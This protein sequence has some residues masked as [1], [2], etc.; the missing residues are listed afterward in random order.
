M[1]KK[2]AR[3]ALLIGNSEYGDSNLAKLHA[4]YH[5]VNRLAQ[6]LRDPNI[7]GFDVEVLVNEPC[8]I[9]RRELSDVLRK[10]NRSDFITLYF[11]GHGVKDDQGRLYLTCTDSELDN[12][13]ATSVGAQFVN[14]MMNESMSK[15][16]LLILDCCH[17]GAVVRGAMSAADQTVSTV[18][19]FGGDRQGRF[20]LTACDAFQYAWDGEDMRE[21]EGKPSSAFSR[22]LIEGLISGDADADRDGVITVNEMADYVTRKTIEDNPRQEPRRFIF[23]ALGDLHFAKNRHGGCG[24]QRKRCFVISPLSRGD[25]RPDEVLKHFIE[26]AC[27]KAGY[28]AVRSDQQLSEKVIPELMGALRFDPMVVAYL[29]RPPWNANVMIEVGFRLA[30]GKPMVM[31]REAEQDDGHPE[32]PL[33]FDLHSHRVIFLPKAHDVAAKTIGAAVKQITELVKARSEARSPWTTAQARAKVRFDLGKETC[34]FFSASAMASQLFNCPD[35]LEN[36]DLNEVVENLGKLMPARQHREFLQDQHALIG[37]IM[38][39]AYLG[40]G[41]YRPP[42]AT[43]PI[44]FHRHDLDDGFVSRAYLPVVTRYSKQGTELWLDVIYLDVT[45]ATRKDRAIP[46]SFVCDLTGANGSLETPHET[47]KALPADEPLSDSSGGTF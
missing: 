41:G 9:V 11:A 13:Q 23:D 30:A 46:G 21:L 16:Q 26:P 22:H 7:G 45:N 40:N 28:T 35:G 34:E 32:E 33:P 20:I 8:Q 36:H 19:N 12:L 42:T 2:G 5:D 38:T 15:Q 31:I 47:G 25:K 29:G 17:A 4:P 18:E 6:A 44:V 37:G 3:K 10:A 39:G 14:G 27:E 1:T 24:V 43:R